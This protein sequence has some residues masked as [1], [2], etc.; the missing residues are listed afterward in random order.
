MTKEV[1]IALI[2][3]DIRELE[4]LTGGLNETEIPSATMLTL[5]SAKAQEVK[6]NLQKLAECKVEAPETVVEVIN[7]PIFIQ[8]EPIPL[9]ETWEEI[10]PEPIVASIEIE[11]AVLASNP[12][13]EKKIEGFA[14]PKNEGIANTLVNK[15]ITDIKQAINMADRFRFQR[16]LFTN[17]AEKMNETFAF[18]NTCSDMEEANKYLSTNFDWK[19]ENET[20]EEFLNLVHRLFV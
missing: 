5:A 18:L 7:T 4:V 11:K 10:I 15:K 20:A 3:K 2:Q 16:E 14:R 17:N 9:P 6:T 12:S 13:T 19:P 8:E 1:L